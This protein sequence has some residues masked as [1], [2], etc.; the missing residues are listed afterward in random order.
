MYTK[1]G[2]YMRVLR[3]RNHEVMGDVA[4]LLNVKTSFLSAVENGK[5]NVPEEWIPIISKH[6]A[7]SEQEK[8]ELLESI[9][10]SRTY[11]KLQTLNASSSQRELA[12]CFARSFEELDDETAKNILKFLS[13]K[14]G[15][16]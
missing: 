3:I 1:F 8:K 7:L 6:Y 15:D 5:K 13:N 4:T 2:E 14:K 12:C 16:A 9:D 11:Y 10:L